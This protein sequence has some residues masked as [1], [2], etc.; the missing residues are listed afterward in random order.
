[1]APGPPQQQPDVHRHSHTQ[2]QILDETNRL[3]LHGH[4]VGLCVC[5]VCA[6]AVCVHVG[7]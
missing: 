1:M 7:M 4:C 2:M 6:K 5:M 3:S